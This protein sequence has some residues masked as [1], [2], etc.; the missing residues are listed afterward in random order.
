MRMEDRFVEQDKEHVV[1]VLMMVV[2]QKLRFV[3]NMD[4]VSVLHINLE[5]QNVVQA[6]E[7]AMMV[8]LKLEVNKQMR[9]EDR[10]VELDWVH[11]VLVLM[12]VVLQKL[13]NVQNMDTVNV[14]HI[15]LEVL[16]V[17]LVLE[18]SMEEK[19]KKEDKQMEQEDRFVE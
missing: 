17:D 7:M 6:L 12:M 16:N 9:M 15:N 3:L 2:L 10:F 19:D 13:Q 1:Q 5:V 4:I 11:V 18:M 14:L 8:R